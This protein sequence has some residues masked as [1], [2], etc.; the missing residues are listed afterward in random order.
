MVGGQTVPAAHEGP[1]GSL[2]GSGA[3]EVLDN[4]SS[5][6]VDGGAGKTIGSKQ[7]K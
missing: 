5:G 2:V 6:T 1:P 7:G 4:E 3:A